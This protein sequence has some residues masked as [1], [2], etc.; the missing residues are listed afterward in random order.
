MKSNLQRR[1]RKIWFAYKVIKA[2]KERKKKEAEALAAKNNR[3]RK[4]GTK[5]ELIKPPI[6]PPLQTSKT[7]IKSNKQ[8]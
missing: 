8:I 3:F 7:D 6:A 2:E 1:I 4:G 5:K